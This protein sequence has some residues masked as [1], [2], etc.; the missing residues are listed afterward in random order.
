MSVI[1]TLTE[2]QWRDLVGRMY[3]EGVLEAALYRGYEGGMTPSN[4][5]GMAGD[6]KDM[7]LFLTHI[8]ELALEGEDCR[9]FVAMERLRYLVGRVIE[10]DGVWWV[11][12]VR[13]EG[14][15]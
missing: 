10:R 9:P 5:I 6:T 8:T 15:N 2:A 14:G 12:C 4:C 11:P 13:V 1:F 7:I 3:G